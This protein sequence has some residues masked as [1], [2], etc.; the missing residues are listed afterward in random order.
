MIR[1]PVDDW[2]EL[3]ALYEAAD[4]LA[5]PALST[6]LADLEQRAHPLVGQLRRML[7]ARIA[8]RDADFL[9]TLPSLDT[10]ADARGG[11]VGEG[12][13]FGPYRLLR[14]L[15]RGG[16][17]EVWLAQRDDGAFE[18]QVAIK[19]LF[20][21]ASSHERDTFAQR[22][23]R[24][25]DILASLHHPNIAGLHDAGVTPQGQ[26]WLA[27]EYVEGE[28]ITA[29]CDERKVTIEGRIRI[30]R[31][32]LLAVQH[33]HANLVIHRDL[34]PANILVTADGEARLLDFGI[35]KLLEPEGGALAETELTKST[36]R[37]LTLAY[38]SPEQVLGAPL[39]TSCDVYSLGVI[40]YE[41]LC[42]E[43]PYELKAVSAAQVEQAILDIDPR[44]PSR[45]AATPSVAE[46]RRAR[47]GSLQRQLGVEL[48]AVVLKALAKRTQDR[49]ASVEGLSADLQRWLE[50]QPVEAR[51]P[52]VSYRL[53]KFVARHRFGVVLGTVGVVG[54]L[55]TAA[56]AVVMGL[57]AR[58]ESARAVASKDFLLEMFRAVDPDQSR[59]ASVSG[60]EI[61]TAGRAKAESALKGQPELQADVLG[62]IAD[63]LGFMGEYD[64]AY[65]TW[66]RVVEIVREG[67]SARA[68][69]GALTE[70][71]DIALRMGDDRLAGQLLDHAADASRAHRSDHAL[72][73]R[74]SE[75]RGYAARNRGDL[76]LAQQEMAES[77]RH[78]G[79]AFGADDSRTLDALLGMAHVE[80]ESARYDSAAALISEAASRAARARGIDARD[81]VRIDVERAEIE[82]VRGR[83]RAAAELVEAG[84][85]RCEETLGPRSENCMILRII[86]GH[87]LLLLGRREDALRM[88]PELKAQ[89][90]LDSSPRRQAESLITLARILA[91]SGRLASEPEIAARLA[92]LAASDGQARLSG[93]LL[94]KAAMAWVEALLFDGRSDAA[95]T[96]AREVVARQGRDGHRDARNL[97]RA[98]VLLGLALQAQG[99]HV[100]ALQAFENAHATHVR[101]MGEGHALTLLYSL[102]QVRSLNATGETGKAAE[103][104]DRALTGLRETL[105]ADAPVL[106]R[107]DALR[108]A[109]SNSNPVRRTDATVV[110]FFT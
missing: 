91:A 10:A 52:T 45:R 87:V 13:R 106:R 71:A 63:V 28:P 14:H 67:G 77:L 8:A 46:A 17:A 61:L 11:E 101:S 85:A 23:A 59:G 74:L 35:A 58:H 82:T 83:Y 47:P 44:P 99:R 34:K 109:L 79:A 19:L 18:R 78:A 40:L 84:S 48:D 81:L 66:T 37:P 62:S 70:Q 96:A 32:V 15:G 108:P 51:A 3:S 36:G 25:R 41:L 55:A 31:Q 21:H 65:R 49:Y 7:A 105:G 57:Q 68:L 89:A 103:V 2:Q 43:R 88:V 9:G 90:A 29:W 76:R 98:Q 97:G 72:M 22:F 73:A 24:E 54:L 80:S 95:L 33:A 50:H 94:D 102:N 38:A 100:E 4:E 104:L 5:E 26:P 12:A 42:G 6:W 16:M 20:R 69:A 1:N 53:A 110:L 60:G 64:E 86:H 39:T 92:T 56:V 27:L 93:A 30:F 107:A 75:V